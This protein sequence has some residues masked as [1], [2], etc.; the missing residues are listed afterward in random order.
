[1]NLQVTSTLLASQAGGTQIVMDRV[2]SN[3]IAG[4]IRRER[5]NSWFGVPT[6]LLGLAR[7]EQIVPEDLASLEDVW[8]GGADLPESVRDEFERK[9]NRQIH[10][11]YGLT[12]VPTVVSIEPRH[13]AHRTGSSG[14]VLPHLDVSILADG[15]LAGPN[16]EGEITIAGR[17]DGEWADAYRPMLG[18]HN[19]RDRSAQVVGDGTLHTGDIGLFDDE[20]SLA[21]RGR[22]TALILRG[23]ANV[24]PAEVERVILEL[25]G[26][27]GVAVVGIPDDRLGQRVA[28]AI[29]VAPDC[30]V[31]DVQLDAHCRASLA[32]YKVPERWLI[33]SLPRNAMGKVVVPQVESWFSGPQP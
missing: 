25:P 33:R 2:D 30:R 22:R 13:T 9:F 15:C 28:A 1:L 8:T 31:D 3:G 16:E 23:G 29:E 21:V 5:I 14:R 19:D 32:R 24:Y 6:M 11:T 10:A 18:Y 20:G 26:V 17:K 27:V 7:D 12:E 4:W